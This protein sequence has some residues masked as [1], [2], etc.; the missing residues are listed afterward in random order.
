M[1]TRI[2]LSA[3]ILGVVLGCG[4]KSEQKDEF[5]LHYNT[6][7][8]NEIHMVDYSIDGSVSVDSANQRFC[9]FGFPMKMICNVDVN[10]RREE[11]MVFGDSVVAFKA[12]YDAPEYVSYVER[13]VHSADTTYKI[14]ISEDVVGLDYCILVD[15]KDC[16]RYVTDKFNEQC[17]PYTMDCSSYREGYVVV[18]YESGGGTATSGMPPCCRPDAALISCN[19]WIEARRLGKKFS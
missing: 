4:P 2:I 5:L 3:V 18:N 17:E 11:T 1:K 10:G 8:V 7:G 16:V 14:T 19:S 15:A 12:D 9:V 13:L 6:M